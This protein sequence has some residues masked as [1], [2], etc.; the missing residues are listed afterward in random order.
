M[1]LKFH[2]EEFQLR[3]VNGHNRHFELVKNDPLLATVC[4]V[5]RRSNLCYS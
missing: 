4:G 5:K 3:T 1:P 2:Q